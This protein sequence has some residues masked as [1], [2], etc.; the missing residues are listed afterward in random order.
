MH[1]TRNTRTLGVVA[2]A[3]VAGITLAGCSTGASTGGEDAKPDPDAKVTIVVGEMPTA[4]QAESLKVF[5]ERVAEFEKLHPNIT[6][7]GEETRYDP[8]TFNALLVGGTAPTT[9]A[10]PFT[11]MQSLIQRGQAADVTDLVEDLPAIAGLSPELKSV[12]Q[13]DGRSYGI[14]RQAYTMSLIYNR[15][16]YA[17]A[18]LNPDEAPTDWKGVLENAKTITEK[19]GKTGFIIPTTN[20]NGGWML[21]SMAYSNGSLVEEVKGD[22]V[23]VSIDT[24]G[25]KA[26]LQLLKDVRWS[27]NAAGANFLLGPDDVRNDYA[28][29]SIGQTVNGA[30]IFNDL[31]VN[32]GMKGEDIGIAPLPQGSKGLG[33]LGGGAIQWFNPKATPEEL[34]AA[35]T[36]AD[37][38]WL[39]RYTDEKTAVDLAA[40]QAKDG[41][42]VG[43]PELPIVSQEAY[44]QYLEWIADSINVARENY[45]AYLESDLD[46]VPEPSVKAQELYA[47]LDPIAQAVLTDE[48]AD[49]DALLAE[50]EKQVQALVDAG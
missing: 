49:I 9:V 47:A 20:N 40:S 5:N 12:V 37:Y 27:A 32:R 7:K 43:A 25:M 10:I 41:N 35:V 36:W 8:S 30:N 45:T 42:P 11:D 22:K 14:V 48:N 33:A 13:A 44:D 38:Y 4:D 23:T 21:T 26:A 2:V 34:A 28:G 24:D 50:A 39:S 16:L 29:G 46:I 6:V 18:G 17:E 19:T 3:A 1:I 31:V 15:A